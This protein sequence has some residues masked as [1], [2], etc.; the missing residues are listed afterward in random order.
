LN[1]FCFFLLFPLLLLFDL[2]DTFPIF[3]DLVPFALFDMTAVVGYCENVGASITDGSG[4]RLGVVDTDWM[5]MDC[6]V[7]EE[8]GGATVIDLLGRFVGATVGDLVGEDVGK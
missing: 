8:V 5:V 2:I 4:V 6:M 1:D 7:G 3:A